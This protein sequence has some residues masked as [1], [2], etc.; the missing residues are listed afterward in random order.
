MNPRVSVVVPVY[1]GAHLIEA[2]LG[3]LDA[4]TIPPE[5]YEVIVVDDGST[6]DTAGAV[7]GAAE[8]ARA[9]IHLIVKAANAGP[10]AARNTG[11]AAAR[12]PVVAFTDAD[13][14]PAPDWLARALER[15]DA[16]PDV[17][18]IEGR[19]DPAGETGTF[20]HQMRNPSG[21]LWMTCNMVYRKQAL[22]AAGGFD[23]RFRAAFLE[24]SDVAF[25]VQELGGEIA[26]EPG[27]IVN[28]QVLHEGRRKLWRDARKRFYNPL[29]YRKHPDLYVRHLRPVVPGLP[30]L[31]LKFLGWIVVGSVTTATGLWGLSVLTV[32]P[33]A[34]SWRRMAFAYRAR[35]PLTVLQVGAV[36]FVQTFWV[37]A[38]M[39]RF[40]SFSPYI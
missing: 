21:G 28:H 19:T 15:L 36:P 2:C 1:Q 22:A 34:L 13:C 20:T 8:Q 27:A 30:E 39:V 33:I 18:G 35:D 10:A 37:L 40:R 25:T 17:A 24:D 6:D 3:A 29:L 32:F 9:R 31:H 38:G 11:V 5:Q 16:E 7:A 12:A 14:A 26:F 23:E 4:Q